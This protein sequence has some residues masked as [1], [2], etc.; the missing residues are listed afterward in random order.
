MK[1]V[2]KVL[3]SIL[4]NNKL[5]LNSPSPKIS[6]AKLHNEF[7]D[8]TLSPWCEPDNYWKAY[9]ALKIQIRE[10]LASNDVPSRQIQFSPVELRKVI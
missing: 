5:I 1:E 8:L 4:E 10:K 7:I 3:F 9:N 2:K 6:I